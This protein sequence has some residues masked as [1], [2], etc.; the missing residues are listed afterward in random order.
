MRGSAKVSAIS[1]EIGDKLRSRIDRSDGLSASSI[2]NDLRQPAFIVGV[3][4][5]LFALVGVRALWS[6]GWPAVG[7]SL[8]LPESG[9][10]SVGA[11]A[12]GWNPAGFGSVEQLPPLVGLAGAV[13]YV[14][15]DS[16]SIA[17][18][19]LSLTAV[20]AGIWGTIRLVR[21]WEIE[22][23]AGWAAGVVLVAGPA[24]QAI[25]DRTAIGYLLG[26]GVLPW[27]IRVASARWPW[28]WM[29]RL[30]RVAA[31]AWVIGLL[32]VVAPP[33]LVVPTAGLML[34]AVFRPTD[35][36]AWGAVAIA[37]VGTALA[38]PLLVPW[39]SVVDLEAYLTIGTEYWTPELLPMA[40][41]GVAF[42]AGLVATAGRRLDAIVLGGVLAGGGAVLA[43]GNDLGFGR[44]MAISGLAI[45]ALG[46]TFIVAGALDVLRSEDISGWRRMIAGLGGAAAMLLVATTAIPL[47]AG[48]AALPNDE[49]TEPLR[50]TTA[51]EGEASSSR[52]LLVGPEDSLPGDSR[53]V[54]GAAYRVVSA[55]V[56]GLW[57]VSL[58]EP[59]A[60]D[61]A[62]Q[63]LLLSLIE[64]DESRAG[65]A[66]SAF[67]IRWV[68]VTGN[69]PLE[70]VFD[71][72][73]DLVSLGGAKRPTFLVDSENPVRA[74]ATTGESW[75]REGTGYQGNAVA[76]ERVFLAETSNSRWGPDPWAQSGWGN[77]V[78]AATG[79]AEFEPIESRRSLAYL[80]AGLLLVLMLFSAF[81][82]RQR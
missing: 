31:A 43:R 11:Y 60:A 27:A 71:G 22:V 53:A 81:A 24:A 17:A 72:Q 57:E 15:F 49:F 61:G 37:L 74:L 13:Q 59:G 76:G 34:R 65:A 39:V 66:L 52:I 21:A 67:G 19:A 7:Y 18:W 29:R 55:P 75:T 40:A 50:F 63:T 9:G 58:P 10:A 42:V 36:R 3:L 78:S 20:I 14:L 12:G 33:L 6:A 23:V 54:R 48:R 30:G 45:I 51:A 47:F 35:G 77:E 26:L 68:V 32:G 79:A 1:T 41:V 62:L 70:A 4:T 8:P 44:E 73:L 64:G 25:G 2:G 5:V 69:T 46:T 80:A 56:P 16:P 82:R 38:L 28:S